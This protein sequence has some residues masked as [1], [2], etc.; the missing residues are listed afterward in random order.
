VYQRRGRLLVVLYVFSP[1]WISSTLDPAVGGVQGLS[2]R[3]AE[4]MSLVPASVVDPGA[5][6]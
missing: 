4:R 5:T 3:I 6:G 2:H 1:A